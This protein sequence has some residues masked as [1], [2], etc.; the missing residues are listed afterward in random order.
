MGL[1]QVLYPSPIG[2][3]SYILTHPD[4]EKIKSH[5]IGKKTRPRV[6]KSGVDTGV[7][8]GKPMCEMCNP[9]S[10]NW[11]KLWH[12]CF[13]LVCVGRQQRMAHVVG[14]LVPKSETQKEILIPGFEQAQPQ[15]GIETMD[16]AWH[17]GS[18]GLSFLF[19]CQDPLGM[20]VHVLAAPCSIHLPAWYLEKQ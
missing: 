5:C 8:Q 14:F 2:H 16:G 1:E 3:S 11:L 15:Q 19:K 7:Y 18:T 20:L 9:A 12:L 10:E 17:G 6:V 4:L 13:L